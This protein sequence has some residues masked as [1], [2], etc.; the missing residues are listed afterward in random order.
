MFVMPSYN[1]ADILFQIKREF[2]DLVKQYPVLSAL[3]YDK[4]KRSEKLSIVNIRLSNNKPKSK[5]IDIY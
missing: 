2:P 5:T 4:D 3:S 1:M